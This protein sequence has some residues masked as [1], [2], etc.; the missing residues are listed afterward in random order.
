MQ[1]IRDAKQEAQVQV[2][3]GQLRLRTLSLEV[4]K[5]SGTVDVRLNGKP[6]K[7][8]S[9]I[10]RSRLLITFAADEIVHAND[11]LTVHVAVG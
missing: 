3:Y 8:S 5:L 9:S 4:A 1:T 7:I 6:V 11:T 10:E 2:R